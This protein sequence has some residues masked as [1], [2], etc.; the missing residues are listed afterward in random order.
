MDDHDIRPEAHRLVDGLPAGAGWDDLMYEI[1]V[2]QAIEGG[3]ADADA[4]RTA[5]H[6]TAMS[7][8]RARFR[9]AY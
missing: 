2:R 3:V 6:E 4:A 1:W 8:I 9:R 5:D 7:R